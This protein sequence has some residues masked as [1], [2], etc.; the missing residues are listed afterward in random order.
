MNTS[1]KSS[2]ALAGESVVAC[3]GGCMWWWL[4]VVVVACGGGCMWWWLIGGL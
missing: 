4:H 2:I 1:T 3:A